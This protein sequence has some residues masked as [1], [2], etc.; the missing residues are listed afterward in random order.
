MLRMA[1][2][3]EHH[4]MQRRWTYK[5][6]KNHKTNFC[7]DWNSFFAISFICTSLLPWEYREPV[8][9]RFMKSHREAQDRGTDKRVFLPQRAYIYFSD[10]CLMARHPV[11]QR[12]SQSIAQH[13]LQRTAHHFWTFVVHIA[14]PKRIRTRG[15]QHCSKRLIANDA[16]AFNVK[17]DRL[18]I[19]NA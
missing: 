19:P 10:C 12:Q 4:L 17:S 1:S 3:M 5:V 14:A 7:C 13:R 9:F 16:V 6:R 11:K 15:F 2:R 18:Y 8:I